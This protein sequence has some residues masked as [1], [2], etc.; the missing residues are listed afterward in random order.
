MVSG[1]CHIEG[2]FKAVNRL[3]LGQCYSAIFLGLAQVA[4]EHETDGMFMVAVLSL[5]RAPSCVLD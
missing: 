4:H 3:M 5:F 2:H 1:Q